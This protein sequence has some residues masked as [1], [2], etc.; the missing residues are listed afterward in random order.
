MTAS[1]PTGRQSQQRKEKDMISENLKQARAQEEKKRKE[2]D[3]AQRPCCHFS[4]PTGWMNDPNGFSRYQGVYHLFYQYYPYGTSWN[5]MHWGHAV[6]EDLIRWKYLPAAMAPDQTYDADGVFSGS[7]VEYQGKQC[8]LYTGVS[9][10]HLPDGKRAVRQTQCLAVGDGTDYEKYAGNP[11]I[12]ADMLPE[13]SSLE[14]FRDP[15]VWEEDGTYYMVVGSR[16]ADGSGQILLYSSENLTEWKF[17]T[18]IDRCHNR[19][20]KMWECPDFF[21]LDHKQVLVV[22]PQD[23]QA[24]GLEFHNGNGTMFLAGTYDGEKKEFHREWVQTVDYGL[25][26]YAPQ[27]LLTEDGRRIM[28]AWMKSWDNNMFP[29]GYEWNGMMTIPRELSIRDGRIYQNPVRELEKYRGEKTEHMGFNVDGECWLQG[30]SGRML[31]LTVELEPGNYESFQIR[32][33]EN[34]RF[35]SSITYRPGQ[36][37]L[38]FDRTYSGYCRDM[39]ATRSLYAGDGSGKLKLRIILDKYSVEIFVNDGQSALTSLIVTPQEADG[40]HFLSEGEVDFSAYCWE[41]NL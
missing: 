37:T 13:G 38:T 7:A 30:I 27:T 34:D 18:V 28:I 3:M 14:D 16:H 24:E 10:V 2:I 1:E 35:H 36:R 23:M 39:A 33:A 4:V 25:D 22:S 12:S 9:E 17:E 5:S 21:P 11:V 6:T 19:Y 8:L 31:D 41:L 20:G 40:I 26:F 32:L 29:E 15:K